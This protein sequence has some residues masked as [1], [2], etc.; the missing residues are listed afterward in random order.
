LLLALIVILTVLTGLAV[1][2]ADSDLDPTFDGDGIVATSINNFNHGNDLAIQ[3]DGKIVVAGVT[4]SNPFLDFAVTRYKPDGSLDQTFGTG[5]IV[6]TSFGNDAFGRAVAIQSDGKIV[7]AGIAGVGCCS[8]IGVVRYNADGSL[9]SSF[10]SGGIVSTGVQDHAVAED[11]VVQSD[12]K[13]VVVG[14]SLSSSPASG[15]LLAVRYNSDGSLDD[16]FDSDG[17]FLSQQNTRGTA[18]TL[19]SDGKIVAAGLGNADGDFLIERLNT[20]G[21]PDP[22]FGTAGIVTTDIN[23]DTDSAEDVAIQPDGKIVAAGWTTK[24]ATVA[25]ALAR[26]N[27]DGSLDTSFDSDGIVNLLPAATGSEILNGVALQTDGKL[28]VAGSFDPGTGNAVEVKRFNANGSPDVAFG[29]GGS[30]I[31]PVGK[32]S[33]ASAVAIQANGKIVVA[34]AGNVRFDP[35]TG[36][37]LQDFIVI[38]YG[39]RDAVN[40]PTLVTG[41]GWINSPAGAF[42]PMPNLTGKATFGFFS[43]YQNGASVPTGNTEFQFNAGGLN[44]KSTSYEWL[45]ISGRRAQFKGAGTINGSGSYHF[46]LTCIDGDKAGGGGID[47]LRIRIWSDTNGLVY[48]NQLNA[49]A[50]GDPT[51]ALGGGSIVIHH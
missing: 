37:L 46:T 14:F 17:V 3:P 23:G 41:G 27:T 9:D 38:R 8:K 18:V 36:D 40:N 5:G 39:A 31:T 22:G 49:P 21:S 25:G 4:L 12:G 2:A 45:V 35:D 50:S 20:D 16:T 48:D 10:G 42:V 6:T 47:K 29:S 32:A 11:L 19:Q 13:I 26:Y 30:V 51:T 34:G 33:V 1:W 24:Q 7:V 28:V 43:K 44:F 15:A